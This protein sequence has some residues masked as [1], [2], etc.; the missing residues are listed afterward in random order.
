MMGHAVLQFSR[1]SGDLTR[2]GLAGFD[3]QRKL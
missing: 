3:L 2:W 1:L